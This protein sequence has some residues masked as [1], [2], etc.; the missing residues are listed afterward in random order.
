[1]YHLTF[2]TWNLA[3]NCQKWP[4][5]GHRTPASTLWCKI[6]TSSQWHRGIHEYDICEFFQCQDEPRWKVVFLAKFSRIFFLCWEKGAKI[7]A[8]EISYAEDIIFLF[9]L[10]PPNQTIQV[11]ILCSGHFETGKRGWMK[12]ACYDINDQ[13]ES[14]IFLSL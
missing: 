12:S 10:I 1:M 7:L 8:D 13:K 3:I 9:W 14:L 6:S 4:S 11:T 5:G 2:L